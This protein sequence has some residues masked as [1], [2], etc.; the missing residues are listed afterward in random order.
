MFRN[1]YSPW[2]FSIKLIC[3]RMR[4]AVK[5]ITTGSGLPEFLGVSCSGSTL[6]VS[7]VSVTMSLVLRGVKKLRINNVFGGSLTSVDVGND[8]V[9]F[10]SV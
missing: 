4:F 9:D 10:L 3:S 8:L 6:C 5:F 1:S 2:T 7:V